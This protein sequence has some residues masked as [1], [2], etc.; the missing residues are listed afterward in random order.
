MWW[1]RKLAIQADVDLL[2]ALLVVSF[3][4]TEATDVARLALFIHVVEGSGHSSEISKF[5]KVVGR[6]K[7]LLSIF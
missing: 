7:I 6:Q 1:G 3:Y 2:H 5:G 4:Q